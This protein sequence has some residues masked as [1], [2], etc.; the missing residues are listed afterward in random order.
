MG[1]KK[2]DQKAKRKIFLTKQNNQSNI[3]DIKPQIEED[4]EKTNG[5]KIKIQKLI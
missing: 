2:E 5:K 1:R 3:I 4:E